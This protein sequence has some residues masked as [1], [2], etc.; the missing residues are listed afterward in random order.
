MRL[1]Q[2]LGLLLIVSV[3]VAW[4]TPTQPELP[5][6]WIQAALPA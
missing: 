1:V 2:H 5:S 4:S 6:P 3:A